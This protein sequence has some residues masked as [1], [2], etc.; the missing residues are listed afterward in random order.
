MRG[1]V[2][3]ETDLYIFRKNKGLLKI[4]DK[5]EK[6]LSTIYNK[7]LKFGKSNKRLKEIV[8]EVLK[9]E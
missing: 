2:G 1:G 8:K 5:E 9:D 7:E 6:I 4:T 3:K